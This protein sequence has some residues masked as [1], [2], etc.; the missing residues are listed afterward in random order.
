MVKGSLGTIL[1]NINSSS[2][3]IARTDLLICTI[4][5]EALDAFI[6]LRY[7]CG[8]LCKDFWD[9][10][11]PIMALPMFS[12]RL[13]HSDERAEIQRNILCK[14]VIGSLTSPAF[15]VKN[16]SGDHSYW[17][18]F[19]LSHVLGGRPSWNWRGLLA[20]KV[21]DIGFVFKGNQLCRLRNEVLA[22]KAYHLPGKP[23]RFKQNSF[24]I[25]LWSFTQ[26]GNHQMLLT[27]KPTGMTLGWVHALP[28]TNIQIYR[29]EKT[30][31]LS[32]RP[33]E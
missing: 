28:L 12:N 19:L 1:R 22:H 27:S 8:K 9:D 33:G 6:S 10:W 24:F 17:V 2:L 29:R 11:T 20:W 32:A 7:E 3:E 31:K 13:S 23:L 26:T 5:K 15:P 14:K 16:N 4:Q 21:P 30:H 25:H 18:L